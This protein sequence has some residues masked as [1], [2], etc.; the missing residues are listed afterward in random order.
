MMDVLKYLY[1]THSYKRFFTH[2]SLNFALNGPPHANVLTERH[3]TSQ[4]VGEAPSRFQ[5]YDIFFY[6]PATLFELSIW[7]HQKA[8]L[9][10]A[11]NLEKRALSKMFLQHKT[12]T[13]WQ[14]TTAMFLKVMNAQNLPFYM[15]ILYIIH[16][17]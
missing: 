10:R 13:S 3:F 5:N 2:W 12:V 4:G 16:K 6:I 1:M 7:S 17:Y 9:Q 11:F 14:L 8:K 15:F